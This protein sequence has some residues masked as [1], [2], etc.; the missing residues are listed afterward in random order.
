MERSCGVDFDD[1]KTTDMSHGLG[2]SDRKFGKVS[3]LGRFGEHK[4]R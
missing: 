3:P 2:G 1:G 4:E